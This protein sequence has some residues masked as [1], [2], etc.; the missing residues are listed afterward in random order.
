MSFV[1][2]KTTDYMGMVYANQIYDFNEMK[3]KKV[4]SSP[5]KKKMKINE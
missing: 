2:F 1:Y 3:L 5:N 4:L